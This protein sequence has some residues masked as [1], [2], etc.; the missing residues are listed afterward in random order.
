MTAKEAPSGDE[1]LHEIKHDGY[2]V[3]AWKEGQRIQLFSRSGNEF[4][5]R[6]D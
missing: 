1:W 4:T 2:R 5:N 3:L 6:F